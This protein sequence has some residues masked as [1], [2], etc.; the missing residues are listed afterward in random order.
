MKFFVAGNRQGFHAWHFIQE[1][2]PGWQ[3]FYG[4]VATLIVLI[5]A[6]LGILGHSLVVLLS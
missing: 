3:R 2:A 1:D 5:A 6:A 4:A